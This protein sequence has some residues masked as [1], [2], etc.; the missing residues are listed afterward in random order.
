[1]GS[2]LISRNLVTP[3]R[4]ASSETLSG[5]ARWRIAAGARGVH[6]SGS[7]P[8]H[9]KADGPV[10]GTYVRLGSTNRQADAALIAELGRRTGTETFDEQPVPDLNSEAIDFAAASQC[11]AERRSLRR[12]DLEA[13]G[14]R[15]VTKPQLLTDLNKY[16]RDLRIAFDAITP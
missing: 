7:R 10:R 16:A 1:V 4:R 8:H 13:L 5:G 12:Q 11:F 6:P 14:L 15:Y 2:V 3:E 9:L